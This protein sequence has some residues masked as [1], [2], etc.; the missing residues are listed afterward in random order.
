MIHAPLR[1]G[2]VLAAIGFAAAIPCAAA[3]LQVGMASVDITPPVGC[4]LSGYFVERVS[5]AVHD[6]LQAK[7][8]YFAQGDERVVLVICDLIGISRTV[9]TDARKRIADATGVPLSNII[10]CATHTHTAPLYF[11]PMRE[12][13]HAMA[14]AK[15]G[16]DPC[17]TIDYPKFLADRIVQSAI[18]ARAAAQPVKLHAGSTMQE[19]P[20]SFNRRYFLEDGS[21]RTNPGRRKDVVRPAGPIDPVVD[22]LFMRDAAGEPM[23]CFTVFSLHLDTTGGTEFSADYPFYLEKSLREAFG[24]RFVSVFG[25]GTC[26]DVNHI[27]LKAAQR[28]TAAEIGTALA[29]TVRKV[30][31]ELPAVEPDLAAAGVRVDV[32]LQSYPPDKVVE[33]RERIKLVGTRKLE[34]LEEVEACKIVDLQTRPGTTVTLEVQAIRLGRDVAIVTLPGEIFVELG[35]AVKKASPFRQTIVVEL[36]NDAVAYVPTKKAFAE[37]GYETVNSRI[38]PGGGEALVDAAGQLLSQLASN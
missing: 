35:L 18:E 11:G 14:V 27:D 33:A 4:R 8:M 2:L 30:L 20:L 23:G 26:G 7:A 21:V 17:E 37:G 6:P 10:V 38:Q 12:H 13:L 31:P 29:D 25:L 24:P 5:T 34:F 16:S 22:V 1:I 32:P 15:H 36:A 28:R 19:P 9:S 3:E